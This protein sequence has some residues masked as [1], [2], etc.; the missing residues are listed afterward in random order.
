VAERGQ[1]LEAGLSERVIDYRLETGRYRGV[2]ERVYSLGPLSMRGRLVAALL[3]GG[4]DA[5]LCH[6]SALVPYRLR[7]SVVTID[8]AVRRQRRD[9]PQLRFHR[10]SLAENEVARRDG[11]RVTTIERTLFDI[12][13]TGAGIRHLAQEAVAKRL[14]TQAK[15]MALADRHRCERGAPAIRRVAGEPHT[16]SRLERRFLRFLDDNGFPPPLANPTI[17]DYDVDCYWPQY[18]LVIEVDEDAH[19]VRF[20]EDRAR[21]RYLAGLGLRVMRITEQSLRD[22]SVLR[23]EVR[24]AAR[25]VR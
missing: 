9:E 13:A 5:V 16:R 20:E 12:A 18:R 1:L 11:L 4:E 25:I 24:R 6:A 14:T 10:L 23:E 19:A 7:T 21:D 17:G 22:E 3:A 8:L 2:H 15:L